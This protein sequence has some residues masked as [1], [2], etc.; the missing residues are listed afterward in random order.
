MVR[1]V[2]YCGFSIVKGSRTAR[3]PHECSAG[4][5]PIC[6]KKVRC[7]RVFQC[8]GKENGPLGKRAAGLESNALDPAKEPAVQCNQPA[9]KPNQQHT[10][11]FR[12]C[13]NRPV[14]RSETS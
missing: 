6:F 13:L 14:D 9:T 4:A 3:K 5:E 7:F 8:L 12:N 10:G 2:P 11:R 1:L